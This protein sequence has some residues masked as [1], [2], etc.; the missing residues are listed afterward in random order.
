MSYEIGKV[1]FYP[2]N[3]TICETWVGEPQWIMQQKLNQIIEAIEDINSRL[4]NIEKTPAKRPQ[5]L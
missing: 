1:E 5:T 4:E 3:Q 2:D